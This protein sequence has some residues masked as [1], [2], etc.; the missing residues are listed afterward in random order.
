MATVLIKDLGNLFFADHVYT[1]L[2]VLFFWP[3][4]CGGPVAFA[5][6]PQQS[7]ALGHSTHVKLLHRMMNHLTSSWL[8]WNIDDLA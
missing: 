8:T 1:Y 4:N 2:A 7:H 3:H 6:F 5:W